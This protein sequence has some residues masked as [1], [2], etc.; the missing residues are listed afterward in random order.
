MRDCLLPGGC[1]HWHTR[2]DTGHEVF[3]VGGTVR[4]VVMGRTP[5][6][7]DIVTT[8]TLHQARAIYRVCNSQET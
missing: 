3:I 7:L 6:D 8:A 2:L 5:K 1:C 4:D